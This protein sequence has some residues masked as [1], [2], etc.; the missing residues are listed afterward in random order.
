[1]PWYRE[2]RQGVAV[3]E[4]FNSQAKTI[5]D[6]L[7]RGTKLVV[8]PFQRAYSWEKKH[9]E[10][11]WN[12]IIKHY[13]NSSTKDPYFLG[14]IVLLFKDDAIEVLDGQ[15]R[16]ATTTILF[17]V[18]RDAGRSLQILAAQNFAR[19]VQ[20]QLILQEDT[21]SEDAFSLEMGAMDALYFKEIV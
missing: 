1:M 18:L 7:G 20:I 4:A 10:T 14:P 21:E 16:L 12:D 3:H 2:V 13:D 19:D 6:L 17:S 8:P 9:V 15:Q 11:F 5:S